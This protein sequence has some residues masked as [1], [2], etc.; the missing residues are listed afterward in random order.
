MDI[1]PKWLSTLTDIANHGLSQ[2]TWSSYKTALKALRTCE[3][4]ENSRMSFPLGQKQILTFIAWLSKRG[5]SQKTINVYLAGIR[6]CHLTE[7]V[8]L[9]ILR[10]PVV[11][12]VLEGKKHVDCNEKSGG[13]TSRLPVTPTMLK[14]LRIELGESSMCKEDKLLVWAVSTLAFNGGFRVHELLAKKS[15]SFDPFVTLLGR[16]LTLKKVKINNISTEILQVLIKS[17]KSDRIGAQVIVDVYESRGTLCPVRAYKKWKATSTNY[18]GKKPAFRDSEGRPLTGKRFNQ[19][20]KSCLGKHTAHTGRKV[21]SHS[22]R[23]GIA[24]LMGQL[25][26]GDQEIMAIGRWS[27]RAFEDYLKLPR[28]KRLE[29]AKK[30]GDLNL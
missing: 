20:L 15:S 19:I 23:S 8:D 16:D 13:D 9:P 24:S 5:L 2:G 14:I 22:F 6:Q 18:S 3:K 17:Q 28:T 10:T 11:N 30:I 4:E 25:G 27:S 29:M 26:Y 21:T 1:D 12:L 7:G